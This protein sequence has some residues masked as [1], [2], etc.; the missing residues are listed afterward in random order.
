LRG[1][2]SSKFEKAVRSR[3]SEGGE[4][5]PKNPLK[6]EV[7]ESLNSQKSKFVDSTRSKGG[8]FFASAQNDGG[9]GKQSAEN[10]KRNL[11]KFAFL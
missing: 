8:G 2:N 1:Q 6:F 11:C 7:K 5:R 3:H 4:S 9:N 10:G